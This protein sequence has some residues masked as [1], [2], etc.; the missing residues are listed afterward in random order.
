MRLISSLTKLSFPIQD[1]SKQSY[2]LNTVV[3]LQAVL[4]SKYSSTLLNTTNSIQQTSKL[5]YYLS[6]QLVE[7]ERQI[8]DKSLQMRQLQSAPNLKRQTTFFT[9]FLFTKP[10]KRPSSLPRPNIFIILRIKLKLGSRV[11]L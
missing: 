9:S 6:Y 3:N 11:C 1:T 5:C 7:S 10:S 2:Y 8:G 4:L